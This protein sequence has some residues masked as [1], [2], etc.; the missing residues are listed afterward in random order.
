MD[1]PTIRPLP[2][3][4][5]RSQAPAAFAATA[6]DFV[7]ALPNFR[8]DLVAGID[9]VEYTF[10]EVIVAKNAAVSAASA[11]QGHASSASTYAANAEASYQNALIAAAAAQAAAGLPTIVGNAGRV[12]IVNPA[13][14]G[15]QW[16]GFTVGSNASGNRTI[17]TAEPSGGAN[18]DIWYQVES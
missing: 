7:G 3:A 8:S 18:G 9:Y 16:S 2:P 12:L 14:N 17:S 5:N 15:V 10:D 6:D 4:P 13:A 1:K 11:A